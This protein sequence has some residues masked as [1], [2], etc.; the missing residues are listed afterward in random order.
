MRAIRFERP[1]SLLMSNCHVDNCDVMN[2][3][4]WF[5]YPS[6]SMLRVWLVRLAQRLARIR[7]LSLRQSTKWNCDFDVFAFPYDL[8]QI[9]GRSVRILSA[10]G[11][12]VRKS[13]ERQSDFAENRISHFL[14]RLV[15]SIFAYVIP[16]IL[17][18]R[19]RRHIDSESHFPSNCMALQFYFIILLFSFSVA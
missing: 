11:E 1:E 4:A 16:C 12:T 15:W 17:F 2:A 9:C 5:C 10:N 14:L 3:F 18:R 8:S 7:I 6:Y 19:R 13:A